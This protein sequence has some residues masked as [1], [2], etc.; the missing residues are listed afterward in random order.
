M[1]KTEKTCTIITTI[2]AAITAVAIVAAGLWAYF[3]F[4]YI[5]RRE[6]TLHISPKIV[7]KSG[8]KREGKIPIL[9]DIQVKNTGKRKAYIQ[10]GVF[11]AWG[12]S[13]K[14]EWLDDEAF[15]KNL[16][17]LERDG[18][19]DKFPGELK[20]IAGGQLY[21]GSSLNP[22]E[23]VHRSALFY[24]PDD[25]YDAIRVWAEFLITNQPKKIATQYEFDVKKNKYTQK[26]YPLENKDKKH[27]EPLNKRKS[28][29]KEFLKLL[30]YN[31]FPVREY[32]WLE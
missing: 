15:Q 4:Q 16:D 7:L 22:G 20:L 5:H 28:S 1:D 13:Y 19:A 12:I 23:S 6:S 26:I 21:A 25:D 3:T 2:C 17:E 9:A 18:F 24:V 14:D 32:L 30:E 27:N 29:V 11:A 10:P 8:R 31:S